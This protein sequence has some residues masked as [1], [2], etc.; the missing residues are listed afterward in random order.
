VS[1]AACGPGNPLLLAAEE[2]E[3]SNRPRTNLTGCLRKSDPEESDGPTHEHPSTQKGV[4]VYHSAE[5]LQI[6]HV[7]M[8]ACCL[9]GSATVS[10][11]GSEIRLIETL[12]GSPCR[13]LCESEIVAALPIRQGSYRVIVRT[14]QTGHAAET[15]FDETIAVPSNS[16]EPALLASKA[17]DRAQP[18]SSPPQHSPPVNPA[19]PAF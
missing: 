15:A 2:W 12:V 18:P 6:H 7:L 19:L 14:Q 4:F 11:S 9:K 13:C 10:T 1:A 3:A 17:E 16:A 8:H 5:A